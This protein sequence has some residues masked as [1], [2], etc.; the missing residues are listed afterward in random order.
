MANDRTKARVSM[1][2]EAA[3]P[4]GA[5]GFEEAIARLGGSPRA[6]QSAGNA[7]Q[8]AVSGSSFAREP[9]EESNSNP[10]LQAANLQS[11]GVLPHS[12]GMDVEKLSALFAQ[13]NEENQQKLYQIAVE[14]KDAVKDEDIEPILFKVPK[15]ALNSG[16]GVFR[17]PSEKLSPDAAV[18]RRNRHTSWQRERRESMSDEERAE[19]RAKD[20]ERKRLKRQE[21][22]SPQ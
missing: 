4:R 3:L 9:G 17:I 6:H 11:E 5:R 12:R 14:F 19:Q 7:R 21:A 8:S 1:P 20:A 18:E 16:S 22:K 15:S 2:T 13:L 10:R